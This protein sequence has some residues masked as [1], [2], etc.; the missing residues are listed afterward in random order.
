MQNVAPFLPWALTYFSKTPSEAHHCSIKDLAKDGE[1]RTA[2]IHKLMNQETLSP[3][4]LFQRHRCASFPLTRTQTLTLW[5]FFR[6]PKM[7]CFALTC[8]SF[9]RP[10]HHYVKTCCVVKCLQ[11][12]RMQFLFVSCTKLWDS[13]GQGHHLILGSY[14]EKGFNQWLIKE[15]LTTAWQPS[16]RNLLFT[17]RVTWSTL[18][19]L[20]KL[21]LYHL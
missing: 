18:V 5:S 20:S 13:W 9:L 21:Q 2:S 3:H 16:W 8:N 6:V 7:K 17:S 15:M 10:S 19:K 1:K 11:L 4:W 12:V 14:T